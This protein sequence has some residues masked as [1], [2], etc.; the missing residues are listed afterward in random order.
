MRDNLQQAQGKLFDVGLGPALY[1]DSKEEIDKTEG[2]IRGILDAKL[3]YTK[4]PLF[5]QEQGFRSCLPAR[6]R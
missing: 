3:V 4:P 6:E 5:Q 1:G 2:D